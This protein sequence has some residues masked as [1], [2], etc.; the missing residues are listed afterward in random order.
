MGVNARGDLIDNEGR[1]IEDNSARVNKMYQ[2]SVAQ[3]GAPR[4]A[5]VQPGELA[6]AQAAPMAPEDPVEMEINDNLD[7]A[8]FDMPNPEKSQPQATKSVDKPRR[9]K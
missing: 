6:E 7:S 2:Q 3:Q 9:Q 5:P 1:V 8:L 4:P